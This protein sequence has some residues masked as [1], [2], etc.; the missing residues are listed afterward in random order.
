M[1]CLGKI[2]FYFSV[3][4]RYRVFIFVF[5]WVIKDLFVLFWVVGVLGFVVI[6]NFYLMNDCVYKILFV[7]CGF[8][9]D[10][11]KFVWD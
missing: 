6:Y 5:S 10:F 2:G 8:I 4:I 9:V 11:E 7:F 3:S 1:V